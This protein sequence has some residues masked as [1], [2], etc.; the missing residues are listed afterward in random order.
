ML[1]KLSIRLLC[2]T[3]DPNVMLRDTIRHY[4]DVNEIGYF[5]RLR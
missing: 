3:D 1:K 4:F 2:S 5:R